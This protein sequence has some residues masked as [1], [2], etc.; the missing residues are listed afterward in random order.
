MSVVIKIVR[1]RGRISTEG[2][3]WK[4]TTPSQI[5]TVGIITKKFNS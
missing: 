4:K 3:Y 2:D 1:V 5:E